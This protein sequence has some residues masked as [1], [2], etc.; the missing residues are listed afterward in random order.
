MTDRERKR[1][2]YEF[3]RQRFPR[4]QNACGHWAGRIGWVATRKPWWRRWGWDVKLTEHPPRVWTLEFWNTQIAVTLD[5]RGL[6]IRRAFWVY[7][8]SPPY[9]LKCWFTL[10]MWR[11]ARR[12][13]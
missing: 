6:W 1:A 9:R 2:E 8:D 5:E 13:Y 4:F 12:V 11:K 7:I 10:G 3:L